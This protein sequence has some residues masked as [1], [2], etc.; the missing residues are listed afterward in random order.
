MIILDPAQ[1]LA[2][3]RSASGPVDVAGRGGTGKSVLA[4]AI[5]SQAAR[6]GRTC[7]LVG[8]SRILDR[9]LSYGLIRDIHK[10]L[11]DRAQIDHPASS[12]AVPP[13]P[14]RPA[15]LLEARAKSNPAAAR[16][17][18]R[19]LEKAREL[20]KTHDISPG[21]I[22]GSVIA[23][24]ALAAGVTDSLSLAAQDASRIADVLWTGNARAGRTF[25][26]VD[27]LVAGR[28]VEVPPNDEALG[29]IL[30]T[31]QEYEASV[32]K[33]VS[34]QQEASEESSV[35]K[36]VGSLLRPRSSDRT[37]S[38][39]H[40][41][42]SFMVRTIGG[43]IA[44]IRKHGTF[45]AALAAGNGNEAAKA[46]EYFMRMRP[47]QG[48]VAAVR[49]FEAALQDYRQDSAAL[50]PLLA[51]YGSRPL[52]S[53]GVPAAERPASL[54]QDVGTLVQKLREARYAARHL[55]GHLGALRSALPKSLFDRIFSAPIE[56]ALEILSSA[57][58]ADPRSKAASELRQLRDLFASTGFGDLLK[59]P[60]DLARQIEESSKEAADAGAPPAAPT[61]SPQ[62]LDLLLEFSTL[63]E[64]PAQAEW[65]PSVKRA[66]TV[67]EALDAAAGKR[68]DV[69]VIDDASDF[70]ADG[71]R[72]IGASGPM[73]HRV[74]VAEHDDAILLEIPHRQ[75][76]AD[77]AAAAS[78]Q[79]SRWLGAPNSFGLLVR[80]D[81][82]RNVEQLSAAADLLVAELTRS[83][84]SASLASGMQAADVIVAAMDEL[85]EGDLAAVAEKAGHGIVVLC[86]KDERPPPAQPGWPAAA[87]ARTAL[88]LG[89]K[90]QRA[91][92]EGTVLEK[93]G[94]VAALVNE[95]AAMSP[96]DE[97]LADVSHR[98]EALGWQPIVAWNG[99]ERSR[100]DLDRLLTAHSLP[101]GP[102]PFRKI[103]E[104]FDLRAP[105][106]HGGGPGPRADVRSE[107]E[108]GNIEDGG[109]P[110]PGSDMALGAE[111]LAAGIP[112]AET[113]PET[114]AEEAREPDE[115][116]SLPATSSREPA[117]AADEERRDGP[118]VPDDDALPI[119]LEADARAAAVGAADSN[120][121]GE[122][123]PADEP[124]ENPVQPPESAVGDQ[125]PD[126]SSSDTAA[127]T[128]ER[129]SSDV[130]ATSRPRAVFRDRRGARRSTS[131]RDEAEPRRERRTSPSIRQADAKLRLMID[132]IRKRIFLAALLLK[133]EGFPDEIDIGGAAVQ[134]FDESRYDDIDLNWTP[135]ILDGELRLRDEPQ[136][137]EWIR[138]AR[139][140]HLFA[141]ASGEPDLVS[142]SAAPL[143]SQ[144]TIVCRE[145]HAA[146][147]EAASAEAGSPALR[148]LADL[149]GLPSG[150][151]VLDGY[152]PVR[153]LNSPADW[154]KPLDPGAETLI[155]L[156]GGFEIRPAAFAQ[157]EPPLIRIEGM[158]SNC[159]VFIDESP[160]ERHDD[161]SWSAPG[162]DAPGQ[163][164]VDIVPG[165]SLTYHIMPDPALREGWEP[166]TAN[167]SLAPAL[168]GISAVCGAMVFSPDGRTVLATEP[169]SSV[170]ALGAR[171]EIKMLAIR[172]DAP[173]ALGALAFEPLFAVLSS[174]GRKEDS[175]ILVLDFPAAAADQ[176][177]RKLDSRWASKIRDMAARRV[178]I[179]PETP[180]AKAAWR[181][182]TREARR[183][184]RVR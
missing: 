13:Q 60:E 85:H 12:P 154:L 46:I 51:Q 163:H 90:I 166:W 98:L 21:E 172:Q 118:P 156:D 179:R 5:A 176:Q 150:W 65:P 149:E 103:A 44:L 37:L 117:A 136:R 121:T 23:E 106:P 33:I 39:Y 58:A 125:P 129:E 100:P 180:A 161:G 75:A 64:F 123:E 144:S 159:Q 20:A 168:A 34:D 155:T 7:L 164:L 16:A 91:A 14:S 116:I 167:A 1:A 128:F 137:L 42:A 38:E 80:S 54:Q 162:W 111:T 25:K 132:T 72:Q 93:D 170:T 28:T 139:P 47:D 17:A 57:S 171:Q 157:G 104:E 63:S 133:P 160:A 27:K 122:P 151:T 101:S 153:A 127:A 40:R 24:R 120:A 8:S 158:P 138:S 182:A 15:S 83:G 110:H 26:D 66:R 70:S 10:V 181:S 145:R 71:L 109:T 29:V 112:E 77:V 6:A 41:H 152:A 108:L 92:T 174:G 73:V 88:A 74:G 89:W 45:K 50:E 178:P 52:G 105:P 55:Q 115:D 9:P 67:Q 82:A 2:L 96:W 59:A 173:A 11:S 69:V 143:G 43:A 19:I 31:D 86:R 30:A 135:E 134:T 95:T 49:T 131:Q 130:P 36:A 169:A 146:A 141:A 62:I 32:S 53:F 165:R 94:K 147:I 126:E 102:S 56:D 183:W 114:A 87:D 78:G 61:Y 68:F 124:S 140:F 22:E 76:D 142:T 4:N 99:A 175:K 119:P 148:R 81:S 97:S 113:P 107:T 79:P 18:V 84:C 35:S 184:K 3:R 48:I 177:P